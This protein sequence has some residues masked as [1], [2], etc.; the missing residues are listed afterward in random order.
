MNLDDTL[1]HKK[2]IAESVSTIA[3]LTSPNKLRIK[4]EAR[5]GEAMARDPRTSP[6]VLAVLA[7]DPENTVRRLVA[8]NEKTPRNILARLV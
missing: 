3:A 7:Q 6:E 5:D 8:A 2:G 1:V 4:E